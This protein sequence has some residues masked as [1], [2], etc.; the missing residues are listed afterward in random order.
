MRDQIAGK[1]IM[2]T[3][4]SVC[5]TGR[6]FDPIVDGHPET[7]RL[8]GMDHFNA[9]FEDSRTGSW[10]QQANGEAIAGPSKG[11]QLPELD[12][13][14]LTLG[15]FFELFPQGKVMDADP[16]FLSK[17]DSLGKYEFG[18]SK[19]KLTGT[20]SLS[21]KEKSWVVGIR[22]REKSKAYDWNDLKSIGTIHDV[23][24]GQPVALILSEDQQSFKAFL[25]ID[26]TQSIERLPGDFLSVGK[27]TLDFR[28]ASIHTGEQVLYPIYAYQEFW[29]SWRTFNPQTEIYVP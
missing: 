4:C 12:S 9:M 13:Y 3:Y 2:V 10:W 6:V 17:Y 29:H 14:Q 15:K 5:R 21:W 28:G 22:V 25:R 19:S 20:D 23:V 27:D 1:E 11:S 16:S 24:A 8:V 26:V 7:F 18:K